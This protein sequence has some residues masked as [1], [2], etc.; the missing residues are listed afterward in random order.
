[1]EEQLLISWSDILKEHP[2]LADKDPAMGMNWDIGQE[3]IFAYVI[4]LSVF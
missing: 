2:E 4:L 1:M 3:M